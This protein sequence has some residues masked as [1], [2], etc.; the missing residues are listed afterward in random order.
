ML[1]CLC[2]IC[3][4]FAISGL[5]V[6][7]EGFKD[8]GVKIKLAFFHHEYILYNKWMNIKCYVN[9]EQLYSKNQGSYAVI[10]SHKSDK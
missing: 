4:V 6:T 7:S 9:S 3:D 2:R 5:G 8:T 1:F 10:K